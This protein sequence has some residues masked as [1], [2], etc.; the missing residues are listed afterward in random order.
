MV[1]SMDEKIKE[2]IKK[3]KKD[4][5]IES[6]FSF[7]VMAAQP[8][9]AE[10]SIKSHVERMGRAPD[11]FVFETSFSEMAKVTTNLP[12]GLTEGHSQIAKAKLY[13]KDF[14]TLLNIIFV[15]GPSS[16]EV[17]DPTKREIKLEE[18]QNICNV[19]AGLIHEFAQ[20]GAGGMLISS[21]KNK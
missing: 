21:P 4:G 3:K 18:M 5:W 17:M 10:A 12:Q 15:Y 9:I 11:T 14:F 8:E 13:T 20:K 1:L 6:E 16:V 19:A 2:E 7:E